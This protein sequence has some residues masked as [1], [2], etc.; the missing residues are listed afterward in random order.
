MKEADGVPYPLA[1]I[2]WGFGGDY[3]AREIRRRI[4]RGEG[5]DSVCYCCVW[6]LVVVLNGLGELRSC[7]P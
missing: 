5:W 7:R 3:A 1:M 6:C 4:G 2:S